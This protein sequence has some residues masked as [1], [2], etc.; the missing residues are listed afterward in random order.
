MK[1]RGRKKSTNVVDKRAYFGTKS[2]SGMSWNAKVSA[3]VGV[4]MKDASQNRSYGQT[5]KKP[6]R[7]RRKK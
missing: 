1:T 7:S 6:A 5:L 2:D 3:F 4:A